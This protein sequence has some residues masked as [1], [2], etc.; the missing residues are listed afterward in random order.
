ML[1]IIRDIYV[2]YEISLSAKLGKAYQLSLNLL[3]A[4]LLT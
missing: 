4:K 2:F 1:F 3:K